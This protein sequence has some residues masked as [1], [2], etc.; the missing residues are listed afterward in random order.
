MNFNL[1][2]Q[3][4]VSRWCS[5][6]CVHEGC[7]G[8]DRWLQTDHWVSQI[9]FYR[10]S[11]SQASTKSQLSRFPNSNNDHCDLGF[12]VTACDV[13]RR[14]YRG[15]EAAMSKRGGGVCGPPMAQVWGGRMNRLMVQVDGRGSR[16]CGVEG[17]SLV[18]IWRGGQVLVACGVRPFGEYAPLCLKGAPLCLKGAPLC[19]KGA[20]LWG[21]GRS[22]CLLGRRFG[23]FLLFFHAA[24]S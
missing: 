15:H 8:V 6:G 2:I 24:K 5:S 14:P 23:D 4:T 18:E 22:C 17:E 1:L 10:Q 13:V 12:I 16:L 21:R 19:L 20:P 7:G 11:I 9:F 3:H